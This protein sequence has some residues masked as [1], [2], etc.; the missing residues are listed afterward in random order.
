MLGL[1]DAL[2]PP[3]NHPF[4]CHPIL[5]LERVYEKPECFGTDFGA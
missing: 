4:H 3:V 1:G 2:V 5:A